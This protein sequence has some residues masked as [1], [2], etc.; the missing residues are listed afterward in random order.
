MKTA[1]ALN[2]TIAILALLILLFTLI[3]VAL[4]Q[5]G[6]LSY[7]DNA[8]DR[9]SSLTTGMTFPLQQAPEGLFLGSSVLELIIVYL[10]GRLGNKRFNDRTCGPS[11][12]SQIA[13]ALD[14]RRLRFEP[15]L[16][17]HFLPL[18]IHSAH[19]IP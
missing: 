5:N 17:F 8:F 6:D 7:G 3:S 4:A 14:P 12:L 2:R 13:S 1:Q 9:S 18:H 16:V 15:S 19:S 11:R 10:G